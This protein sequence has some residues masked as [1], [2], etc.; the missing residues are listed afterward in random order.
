[1]LKKIYFW[2]NRVFIKLRSDCYLEPMKQTISFEIPD[3]HCSKCAKKIL[4]AL[5]QTAGIEN[6]DVNYGEKQATVQ[7]ESL[8]ISSNKIKAMLIA[9][10]FSA[11]IL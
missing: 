7:I 3:I 4:L 2:S 1:M 9:L 8:V 11:M 6:S 5:E 10:G